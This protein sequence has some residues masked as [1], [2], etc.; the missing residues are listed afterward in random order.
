MALVYATPTDVENT[1][2]DLDTLPEGPA[3]DRWLAA[4]SRLVTRATRADHY[5]TTPAGLPDDDTIADAFRDA[6]I[7]QVTYW[8]TN[9]IDPTAGAGSVKGSGEA[10]SSSIGSGAVHYATANT[11]VIAERA[12]S[13]HQLVPDAVYA[14]RD[15]GMA[16]NQVTVWS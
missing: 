9:G 3:L 14:L 1:A 15:A 16:S 11:A 5:A 13:L 12:A 2:S 8:A 7:I 6:T 4:A 10:Q